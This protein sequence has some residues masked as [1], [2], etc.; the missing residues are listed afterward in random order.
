[1]EKGVSSVRLAFPQ[2][3]ELQWKINAAMAWE[4]YYSNVTRFKRK[5]SS[6]VWEESNMS[7]IVPGTR[8]S[9]AD[10]MGCDFRFGNGLLSPRILSKKTIA[11]SGAERKMY[12]KSDK[13]RIKNRRRKWV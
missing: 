1:M 10:L 5:F 8:N 9:V 3:K 7:S 13:E 2:I 11:E 6:I 12:H 4:T